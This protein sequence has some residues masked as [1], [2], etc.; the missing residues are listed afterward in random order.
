MKILIV[1]DRPN[2]ARV[3]AVALRGL[4]CEALWSRSVAE[5][6]TCLESNSDVDAVFLDVNLDRENGFDYLS[7]LTVHR[8]LLP[9]IMFSAQSMDEIFDEANRRGA[10]GCITKPFGME[11]LRAMITRLQL[12]TSSR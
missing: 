9:V 5:A 3:T 2:L 1:D 4:G 7:K 8:P 6:E 11:E 10:F 12:H